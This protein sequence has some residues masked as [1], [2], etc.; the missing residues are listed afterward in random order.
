MVDG[1]VTGAG[2][3]DTD[4]LPDGIGRTQRVARVDLAHPNL[5]PL[6]PHFEHRLRVDAEGLTDFDWQRHLPLF[7]DFVHLHVGN[8][9]HW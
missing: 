5:V 2:P 4:E 7:G 3:P 1:D 6:R 8:H 9:Y